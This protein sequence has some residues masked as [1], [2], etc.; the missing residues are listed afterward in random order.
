MLPQRRVVLLHQ[1]LV[2]GPLDARVT[3][4][5]EF[6]VFQRRADQGLSILILEQRLQA[7]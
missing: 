2:Q 3:D 6:R 7:R 4:G 1:V 5:D